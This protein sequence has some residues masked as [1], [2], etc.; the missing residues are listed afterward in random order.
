MFEVVVD[1]P[2]IHESTH[3]LR[4]PLRQV[5]SRK[6]SDSCHHLDI[7]SKA[8]SA[9]PILT[10]LPKLSLVGVSLFRSMKKLMRP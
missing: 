10:Q 6:Q 4:I 3:L 1:E 8:W 9:G 7:P 2:A 5:R